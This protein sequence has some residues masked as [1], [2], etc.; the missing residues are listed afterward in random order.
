M[1][2]TG[3]IDIHRDDYVARENLLKEIMDLRLEKGLT[4]TEVSLLRKKAESQFDFEKRVN[5]RYMTVSSA[6]SAL[7]RRFNL[8]V[9]DLPEPPETM[10][11]I[12]L[13]AITGKT[14]EDIDFLNLMRTKDKM[15][16]IR[17]YLGIT[18]KSI[19]LHES[20]AKTISRWERSETDTWISN[21]Q[22]YARRLGGHL[23]LDISETI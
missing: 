2:S 3:K 20:E 18:I 13:N 7:G 8:R 19:S 11:S 21:L 16:R 15:V 14:S 22:R 17:F 10:D 23:D 4:R 1:N 12:V 6:T 9:V 5:W